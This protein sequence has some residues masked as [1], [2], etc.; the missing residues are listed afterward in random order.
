MILSNIAS[1]K[2]GMIKFDRVG[3]HWGHKYEEHDELISFSLA[4]PGA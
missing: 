3:I 4:K 2:L 1:P